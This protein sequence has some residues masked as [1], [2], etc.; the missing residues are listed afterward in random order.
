MRERLDITV[1]RHPSDG[2]TLSTLHN[3]TFLHRR[4][5]DYTL[6]E[7]KRMFRQFVREN[8]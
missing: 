6:T 7:A 1:T 8:S 4:Y 2:F 3:G 5:I